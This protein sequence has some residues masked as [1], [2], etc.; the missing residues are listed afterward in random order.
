MAKDVNLEDIRKALEEERKSIEQEI[1]EELNRREDVINPDRSDLAQ[2]YDQR[3]R[4]SAI[5][6]RL[7]DH[8][9]KVEEALQRLDDGTYGRCQR[10][11]N[12]IA[13]ERLEAMP[14]ATLCVRC[15]TELE[16]Q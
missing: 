9:T 2:S 10:C 14:H 1:E 5:M 15:Q 6:D 3:Q 13:P 16:Q 7:E 12:P 11:G 8:L 4:E